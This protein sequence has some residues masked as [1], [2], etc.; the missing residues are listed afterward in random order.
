MTKKEIEDACRAAVQ[1]QAAIEW[2]FDRSVMQN[3]AMQNPQYVEQMQA[4]HDMMHK[5]MT[6]VVADAAVQRANA[7]ADQCGALKQENTKLLAEN[8]RLR[9]QLEKKK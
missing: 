1:R 9:R 7:L 3:H 4:A 5:Q 2:G 6:P 8:A